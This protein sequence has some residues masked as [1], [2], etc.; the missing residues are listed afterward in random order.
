MA[1]A[2]FKLSPQD[3][4]NS[5]GFQKSLGGMKNSWRGSKSSEEFLKIRRG[6]KHFREVSKIIYFVNGRTAISICTC[7]NIIYF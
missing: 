2:S 4:K 7:Q 1:T 6:F 5:E 3:P